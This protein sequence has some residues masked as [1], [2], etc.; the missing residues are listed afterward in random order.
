MAA[1]LSRGKAV[2][3]AGGI[4][5]V[6]WLFGG[7]GAFFGQLSP[8]ALPASALVHAA[9]QARFR[10]LYLCESRLCQRNDVVP[11]RRQPPKRLA[12]HHYMA[13]FWLQCVFPVSLA[14]LAYIHWSAK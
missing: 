11:R 6:I 4:L 12:I 3:L 9:P 2:L 1:A 7:R 5:G 8:A 13:L 14:T 10:G